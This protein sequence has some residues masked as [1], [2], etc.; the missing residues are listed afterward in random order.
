MFGR[1]LTLLAMVSAA[2]ASGASSSAGIQPGTF[3][4]QGAFPTS[5]YTNYYNNPTATVSQVQPVISDPVTQKTYPLALTDP[6][7]IPLN[8]TVD[9]HPLP[10]PASP[11]LVLAHAIAQVQSIATNPIFGNST[12]ARCQAALEVGKFVALTTPDQGPALVVALCE[13]FNYSKTCETSY[14]PLALGPVITQVI[15]NADV[16]GYDGQ[17]LC[18]NFLSLCPVPPT[19]PLNLTSWFAKPK[20]NPLPPPKTPSGTRLKVLHLSDAHLDPRYATGSESNCTSGLCCRE[21]NVNTA[22]PNRTLAPAPR[23]GAYL[24]DTPFSLLT[25]ALESIPPLTGTQDTGFAWTVYTGDLVSHDPDNQLSRDYIMYAE[26]LI[27]DLFKRLLGS[28]PVYPALGNHDSYNQAQD[29]PYSIGGYLASQFSWNYDHVAYLWQHEDWLPEAAV[30]LARAHYAA[31][32]VKRQDGLRV[33][34][35]NTDLWYRANYFNYIN[36]TYPDTSGM[37]RFLTDELQDAED[38]GDRVWIVGHVLSGWDGTNPMANPSNLF[39][40]IVD[41]F[42]P[43]VIANI[44]FGHTH[45]DQLSI[46]YANNGTNMS[47][48]TAQA[49][50][51][52]GPS[53][54]PLTNLNSG[55]RVYE[56]D[57]ATFDIVDAHTWRSEVNTFPALDSQLQYGPTY[58]YEYNTRQAYGANF[59]WGP[60]DPLNATFWH[61]VTEVMEADPSLVTTFNTYQG[62]GSVLTPPCT[63]TCATAKICYI[64]SGSAP[65]ARQNCPAGYGSV[66]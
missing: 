47:A 43:H 3:T 4:A 53:I 20:P 9:P 2:I 40:Q 7:T 61:K 29:A 55:F 27:Y 45:E 34:T 8:N 26:T 11:S 35:L 18:Q 65:L 50:S 13:Y 12:C 38:A 36:L 52:I 57:S 33:I 48:Q 60:N 10:P 14:G 46:F 64:R 39:Y 23:Y 59:T 22:S 24:C 58:S 62:K 19:S 63:G 17:S 31:Y 30:E 15:A 41:R 66:Q 56:V 42:S 32:M 16:G 6:D 25:S 44:F 1:K 28:G 21:N 51:W 54:T 49:V 5:L 37:L